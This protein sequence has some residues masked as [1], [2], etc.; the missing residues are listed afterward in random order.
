MEADKERITQVISNLLDNALKFT[1]NGRV[2]VTTKRENDRKV[3]VSVI[4]TGLGIAPAIMP[5]LFTKFAPKSQRHGLGAVHIE[6]HHGGPRWRDM[7]NEQ[8]R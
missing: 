8:L 4:D 2:A 7:G 1:R 6:E 5:R 3:S